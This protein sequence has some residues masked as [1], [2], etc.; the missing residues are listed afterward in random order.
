MPREVPQLSLEEEAY[1]LVQLIESGELT[2]TK[3]FMRNV[4][5]DMIFN[6]MPSEYIPN[7]E[8]SIDNETEEG[9]I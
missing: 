6:G 9:V 5:N 4:R 7:E 1:R 2:D 3:L 8:D